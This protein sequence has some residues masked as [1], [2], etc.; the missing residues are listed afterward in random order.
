MIHVSESSVM[1]KITFTEKFLKY[2]LIK[3]HIQDFCNEAH[4]KDGLP[5]LKGHR[6]K[7]IAISALL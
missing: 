5:Y 6:A 2:S 1:I 4:L 3:E 7:T